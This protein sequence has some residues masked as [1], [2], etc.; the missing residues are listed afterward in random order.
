[1]TDANGLDED[2]SRELRAAGREQD[3]PT[4][5]EAVQ[6]VAASHAGRPLDEVESVLRE[7]IGTRTGDRTLLSPE[8]LTGAAQRIADSKP[9]A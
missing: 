8:A 1:M 9:H 4:V 3:E 7:A 2:I 5:A 6:G